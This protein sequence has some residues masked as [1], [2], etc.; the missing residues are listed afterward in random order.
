MSKEAKIN[1]KPGIICLQPFHFMEFSTNGEVYTCCPA[2]TRISIGNIKKNTIPEI[3]NSKKA[4]YI[5]QKMYDGEWRDVCKPICPIISD[6][7]RYDNLILHEYFDKFECLTPQIMDEIRNRQVCLESMPTVFNL[8][9][10]RVCNLSCIM[11]NRK[12]R[13]HNPKVIEKTAREVFNHLQAAKKIVLTGM[14]D[15]FARP[16]T[17]DILINFDNRDSDVR[18]DIITNALLL[19][20]Y[21]EKVRRQKFGNL[22]ISADAATKETYEKIRIGGTWENLL[23]SLALVKENKDRFSSVT[24]NMTVMRYNYREIPAFIDFAESYGFNVSFQRVRGMYGKQNFFEARD[25]KT[26]EELRVIISCEQPKIR[27]VTIFWGDL[28]EFTGE[29]FDS[30]YDERFGRARN[31]LRMIRNLVLLRK[32]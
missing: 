18:F 9:N 31:I 14:G 30:V 24:I 7:R 5:R 11:C 2:W 21:W 17:R 4:Q 22:L 13:R 1:S 15:P 12:S 27:A 28:L 8:S 6:Y 29:Q 3:W 19:P 23:E 10:S 32:Y 20:K 16:D 26:L 25:A